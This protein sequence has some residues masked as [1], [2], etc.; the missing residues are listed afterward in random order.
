[1][2]N[3]IISYTLVVRDIKQKKITET[4]VWDD[5]GLPRVGDCF[6][7]SCPITTKNGNRNDVRIKVVVT[8]VERGLSIPTGI[9]GKEDDECF[10]NFR[11][12]CWI[13]VYVIP[14]AKKH[15]AQM[16]RLRVY[17]EE[18]EKEKRERYVKSQAK[19]MSS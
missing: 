11:N 12:Q 8:E 7:F 10:G 4:I 3:S 15:S 2:Q 14:T 1:M 16:E 13:N 19:K 17:F 9:F 6:R 18:A 5:I